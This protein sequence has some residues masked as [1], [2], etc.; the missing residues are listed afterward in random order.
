M[1]LLVVDRG[2]RSQEVGRITDGVRLEQGRERKWDSC[3]QIRY[4]DFS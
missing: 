1:K 2:A 4:L 3:L